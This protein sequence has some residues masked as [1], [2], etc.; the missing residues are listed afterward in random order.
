MRAM[1]SSKEQCA[2][3]AKVPQGNNLGQ[4]KATSATSWKICRLYARLLRRGGRLLPAKRRQGRAG[5]VQA[6]FY[7]SDRQVEP[8]GNV[9]H[10]AL[11]AQNLHITRR[12]LSQQGLIL[13]GQW[14]KTLPPLPI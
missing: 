14:E 9:R 10:L 1:A 7:R 5:A 6:A 11:L 3:K 13:F 12:K 4:I 8:A 2:P